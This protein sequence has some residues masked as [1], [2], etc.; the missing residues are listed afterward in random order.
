[1][2]DEQLDQAL[3]AAMRVALADVAEACADALLAAS[4]TCVL[5][6]TGRTPT[7]DESIEV[8]TAAIATVVDRSEREGARPR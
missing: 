1:M 8:A 5:E 4:A 6:A 3:A 7:V 2:T